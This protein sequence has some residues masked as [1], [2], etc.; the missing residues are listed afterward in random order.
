M[1]DSVIPALAAFKE[2]RLNRSL[3]KRGGLGFMQTQPGIDRR[4]S[5]PRQSDVYG[6]TT[7]LARPE[8]VPHYVA[9]D[10]GGA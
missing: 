9:C 10:V 8:F 2:D 1:T 6:G 5:A 4:A 7:N 3:E